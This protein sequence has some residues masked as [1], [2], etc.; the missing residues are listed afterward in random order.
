MLRLVLA[1]GV[2][3]LVAVS[4]AAA[5]GRP[6]HGTFTTGIKNAPAGQLDGAWQIDLLANGRYTI[7]RNGAVLIR[8]RDTETATTISFGHETGPAACTGAVGAATY[9]WSLRAGLLR[10]TA[11]REG[12]LGRH[13]VLT[14]HPLKKVG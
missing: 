8:G 13:V 7:Q 2:A 1:T 12:C 10:L 6:L 3:L 11:V 9:R 14:T 5:A 4:A